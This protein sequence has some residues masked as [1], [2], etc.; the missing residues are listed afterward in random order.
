M[1]PPN[2]FGA[3]AESHFPTAFSQSNWGRAAEA[4]ADGGAALNMGGT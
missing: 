4:E 1:P 3:G 2:N